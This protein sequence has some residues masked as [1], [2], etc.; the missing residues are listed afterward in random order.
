MASNYSTPAAAALGPMFVVLKIAGATYL[1]WLGVKMWRRR[2][3]VTTT[4]TG[5]SPKV[6]PMRAAVTG[7]AF[8]LSNPQA[9]VF[10]VALLPAVINPGA[11]AG[12]YVVLGAVLCTVMMVVAAVYITLGS[13][14]RNQRSSKLLQSI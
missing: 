13:R 9:I 1:V 11:S 10:Y 5:A 2:S 14:A 4:A 8:G 12:L 6:R 7:F 3:S